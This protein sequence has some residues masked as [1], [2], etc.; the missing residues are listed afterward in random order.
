[1]TTCDVLDHSSPFPSFFLLYIS[2][3]IC[4]S[5]LL[6]FQFRNISKICMCDS[7]KYY[8]YIIYYS[9]YFSRVRMRV[10]FFRF[11]FYSDHSISANFMRRLRKIHR[12][13]EREITH[14]L[15]APDDNRLVYMIV[16]SIV[17]QIEV[18]PAGS[19]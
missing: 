19:C 2:F 17:M 3:Q 11:L 16:C 14:F 15:V 7:K 5:L 9:E 18:T 10:Y 6:V 1:M 8:I 4:T 13:I 12:G